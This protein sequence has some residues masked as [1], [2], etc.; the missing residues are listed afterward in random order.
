MPAVSVIMPVYGAEATLERSLDSLRAQTFT[1]WEAILVDDGSPDRCGEICDRAAAADG[2]FRVI[3]RPNGGVAAARQAGIEAADGDYAIHMDPDDTVSPE[4]L[5]RLTECARETGAGMVVCDF[6]TI[7]PRGTQYS[8]QQP[9]SGDAGDVLADLFRGLHGSC[10]NKLIAR[11]YYKAARFEPGL[12]L[13]E[14]LLYIVR[15]LRR[16]PSVAYLGE[17]FYQYYYH[18]QASATTTYTAEVFRRLCRVH[19]LIVAE[20]AGYPDV[21]RLHRR[22]AAVYLSK[23]GLSA[24][25][26]GGAEYRRVMWPLLGALLSSRDSVSRKSLAVAACAGLKPLTDAVLRRHPLY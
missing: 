4:M 2:R 3:H 26:L 21:E 6:V 24:C 12:N 7:S 5:A 16:G 18:M 13:Q 14:D 11:E 15:V 9:S 23:V 1:D 22:Q 20:L 8:R 10:C 25:D 19:R 17:A